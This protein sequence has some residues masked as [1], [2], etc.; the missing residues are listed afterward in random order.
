MHAVIREILLNAIDASR[1]LR[2]DAKERKQWQ[3]VLAKLMPYQVG[4]YGQLME[5]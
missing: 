2:V 4:R 5:S 3:Q 1:V